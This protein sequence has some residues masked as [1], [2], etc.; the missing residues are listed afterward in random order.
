MTFL[1]GY[2]CLSPRG[3]HSTSQILVL[4]WNDPSKMDQGMKSKDGA[5]HEDGKL[6]HRMCILQQWRPCSA[7]GFPSLAETFISTCCWATPRSKPSTTSNSLFANDVFRLYQCCRWIRRCRL[8]WK[9]GH[10]RYMGGLEK[11]SRRILKIPP[12]PFKP[13]Q[14]LWARSLLSVGM[15]CSWAARAASTVRNKD[16]PPWGQRRNHTSVGMHFSRGCLGMPDSSFVIASNNSYE[17]FAHSMEMTSAAEEIFWRGFLMSFKDVVT[18]FGRRTCFSYL[19]ENFHSCEDTEPKVA[20]GS[21]LCQIS[22]P[23]RIWRRSSVI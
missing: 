16:Q 2:L 15:D 12:F 17:C 19:Q 18:M 3:R 6:G 1:L 10:H 4:S 8:S 22:K 20:R 13:L 21:S 23:E 11:F 14:L 9:G 5:E 7:S